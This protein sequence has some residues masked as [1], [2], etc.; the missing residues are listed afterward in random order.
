MPRKTSIEEA[1]RWLEMA[2]EGRSVAQIAREKGS[3]PR[4]VSRAI[5]RLRS[6]RE[7]KEIKREAVRG[8]YQQ[9]WS[10]LLGVLERLD[11]V[12]KEDNRDIGPRRAVFVEDFSGLQARGCHVDLRDPSRPSVRFPLEESV[13]WKLLAEHLDGDDLLRLVGRWKSAVGGF[14]AASMALAE[15]V[16]PDL[17]GATGLEMAREGDGPAHLLLQGAGAVHDAALREAGG[18]H[19]ALE[20]LAKRLRPV[21]EEDAVMAG[22]HYVARDLSGD[23]ADVAASLRGAVSSLDQSEELRQARRAVSALSEAENRLLEESAVVQAGRLLPGECRACARL[24]P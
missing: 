3:D 7:R 4:T 12:L 2:D 10:H 6:E 5:S 23:A 8:A 13:D 24:R 19:G 22:S 11:E 21:P 20:S 15:R 18:D 1:R 14:V 16:K 17:Q 9:H